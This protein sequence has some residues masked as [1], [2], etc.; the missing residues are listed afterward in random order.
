MKPVVGL[1]YN[2]AVPAVI[3]YAPDLVEYI[4]V[5]PDRLWYDLGAEGAPGRRFRDVRGAIEELKRCAEGRVVAGHGIGLSLPSA[6]PLDVPQVEH[7]SSL[8]SDLGFQWYSEHLS[9]FLVGRGSVPNSQAGLGLPVPYDTDTLDILR[10][11]LRTLRDAV[12]CGLLMENGAFFTQ[13]PNMPMTEPEFLNLLHADLNCGTLLDLHNLYVGWRNG[14]PDPYTY[15]DQLAPDVVKEIHLAGGD[16][17]A[18]FYTDSHSNITPR[19]VWSYAY[20]MAPKLRQLRAITFEF[21]ESYFAKIRVE[22]VVAEL[23]RLHELA[24][25]VATSI[26]QETCSPT[27]NRH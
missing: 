27:S 7:V 4:E 26:S 5:I 16:I 9:M 21:H 6:I 15:L 20:S 23:E 12:G 3:D 11:K 8:A 22:G 1:L 14:G 24:S 10:P 2:P 18:G 19:D 25:T 13:I 17:I